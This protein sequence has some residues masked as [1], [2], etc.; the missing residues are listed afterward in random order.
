LCDPNDEGGLS[1]ATNVGNNRFRVTVNINK[2]SYNAANKDGKNR[3]VSEIYTLVLKGSSHPGRCLV[4]IG[5]DMGTLEELSEEKAKARLKN[6]L[7][8]GE[9]D[10]LKKLRSEA[11]Q[12]LI[13]QKKKRDVANR[14]SRNS[15]NNTSASSIELGFDSVVVPGIPTSMI[16][17]D[18]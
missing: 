5:N 2:P 4:D 3:I 9:S 17:A 1:D 10:D 13:E 11:I 14:I 8:K 12:D 16:K 6:E 18:I 7:S 15:E